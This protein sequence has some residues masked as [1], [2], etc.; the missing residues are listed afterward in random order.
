MITPAQA[1]DYNGFLHT[2]TFWKANAVYCA[3][4]ACFC[5]HTLPQIDARNMNEAVRAGVVFG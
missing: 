3:R 4:I 5:G 2:M 1:I